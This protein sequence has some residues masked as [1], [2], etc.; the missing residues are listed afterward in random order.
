MFSAITISLVPEARGGPFVFWNDLARSCQTAAQLGFDA[1]EIFPRSAEELDAPHVRDLLRKN[2][3]R[4]AAVGT[5]A[6]WVVGKLR[7]TD[8][9]PEIRRRA[10]DF[11][12]AIIS[13][14]GTFNAPAIVGSMQGRWGEDQVTRE[15]SLA[16]L[17]EALEQ[18][19]P[20]AHALGVPL[21][22][23]PLNRYETNLLNS[24]EAT[25]RFLEGLR[26]RNIRV[27]ADLFHMNIEE[28]S[29]PA[30][31]RQAGPLLG[32]LHFADSNRRAVGFGHAPLGPIAQTLR[33]MEY[34]GGISAEIL[35]W[36]D[37]EAAARQTI[38]AYRQHF[39]SQATNTDIRA[40]YAQT[41]AHPSKDQ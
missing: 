40:H 8:P 31:L 36:P 14:A 23:E 28:E 5:G 17:A 4:L 41:P 24:M 37:S 25:L 35:P 19:A 11:V 20:R 22:L 10:I 39:V 21:L 12:A 38:A 26:T 7:L 15:Q 16:W 27:L 32:H 29:I 2:H 18:L 13:F 34:Q 30:A 9:N 6:G 33:E 3:L 1:V